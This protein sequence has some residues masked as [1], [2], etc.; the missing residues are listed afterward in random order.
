MSPVV[1][2]VNWSLL[3]GFPPSSS[4][5]SNNHG[6][7]TS[8]SC[9]SG[10]GPWTS[11]P[12][13]LYHVGIYWAPIPF[14][15]LP[16]Q[17]VKQLAALPPKGSPTISSWLIPGAWPIIYQLM[18]NLFFPWNLQLALQFGTNKW[19]GILRWLKISINKSGEIPGVKIPI[20]RKWAG[21]VKLEI[22]SDQLLRRPGV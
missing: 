6:F 13:T 11:N 4:A 3:M 21:H 20:L 7:F 14:Q 10:G 19:S 1:N 5:T 22:M 12:N 2:M 9:K 18:W 17:T 8:D 15:R 16:T